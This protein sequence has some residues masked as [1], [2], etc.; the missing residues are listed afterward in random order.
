MLAR[1]ASG[2]AAASRTATWPSFV[3]P[4]APLAK[5][6]SSV[7]RKRSAMRAWIVRTAGDSIS[8]L[9][10]ACA[11]EMGETRRKRSG[12]SAAPFLSPA[13]GGVAASGPITCSMNSPAAFSAA[14]AGK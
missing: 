11:D 4:S 7:P 8:R 1:C 14:A 10:C 9:A 6:G 5:A 2:S 13:G 3:K 12:A